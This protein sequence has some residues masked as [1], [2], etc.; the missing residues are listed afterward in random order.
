MYHGRKMI[1]QMFYDIIRRLYNCTIVFQYLELKDKHCF[2]A[3]TPIL[4]STFSKQ[5]VCKN[6]HFVVFIF[7]SENNKPLKEISFLCLLRQAKSKI[8]TTLPLKILY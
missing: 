5:A 2:A 1:S 6:T 3:R 8:Y 7:S 4:L